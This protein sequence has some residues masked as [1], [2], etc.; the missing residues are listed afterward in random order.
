MVKL[1]KSKS[2]LLTKQ[3]LKNYPVWTWDDEHEGLL[4]I[5]EN[6]PSPEDYEILI[7]KAQFET[8][9]YNFEGYLVRDISIYA[10]GIYVEDKLFPMNLKL[11]ILV[12]ENLKEIFNLLKCKPFQFFPIRYKSAVHLKG[13][14]EIKGS[15]VLSTQE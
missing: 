2:F 14:P 11:Q 5:S 10:F 9:G 1:N 6:Q 3:D 4:P 8:N 12:Q 7:I 13:S 15:L